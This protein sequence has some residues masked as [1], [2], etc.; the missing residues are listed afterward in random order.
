[1]LKTGGCV[2]IAL[3]LLTACG[4]EQSA[5]E[6][7]RLP[8]REQTW[9]KTEQVDLTKDAALASKSGAAI[10]IPINKDLQDKL[11]RTSGPAPKSPVKDTISCLALLDPLDKTRMYVQR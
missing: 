8:E 1:M 2:G 7:L 9:V 3:L 4:S 6:P 11:M 10:N 5:E